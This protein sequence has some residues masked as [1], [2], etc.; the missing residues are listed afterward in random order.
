MEI[1]EKI[2]KIKKDPKIWITLYAVISAVLLYVYPPMQVSH[3]E[4][5]NSTTIATLENQYRTTLA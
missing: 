3:F 1:K 5:N 2:E 4:I